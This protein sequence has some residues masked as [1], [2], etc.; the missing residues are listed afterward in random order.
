MPR[1]GE[2]VARNRDLGRRMTYGVWRRAN[3]RAGHLPFPAQSLLRSS[4]LRQGRKRNAELPAQSVRIRTL[5]T[6]GKKVLLHLDVSLVAQAGDRTVD[7]L[8]ATAKMLGKLAFRFAR[9]ISTDGSKGDIA[10]QTPCI[11][12]RCSRC[13]SAGASSFETIVPLFFCC[14]PRKRRAN[15]KRVARS[16]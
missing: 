6:I 15:V 4:I 13:S 12:V 9:P 1:D 16:S 5:S 8:R 14:P 10:E 11:G 3:G 7:R 2:C